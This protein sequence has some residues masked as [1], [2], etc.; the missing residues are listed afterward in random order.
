[1]QKFDPIIR[2]IP[3]MPKWLW[4]LVYVFIIGSFSEFMPDG[5]LFL[6][7]VGL[8][9]AFKGVS[10]RQKQ[11]Q[12]QDMAKRIQHLKDTV[13]L[14]DRQE[15]ELKSYILNNDSTN[16]KATATHLLEK[17]QNI[18]AES[19]ELKGHLPNEVFRR[20]NSRA[21]E[22]KVDTMMQL[23]HLQIESHL[24]RHAEYDSQIE[25][26]A[27]ELKEYYQNVQTDH[28]RILK[29]LEEADN[30]EELTA[31]H[32][33][34]MQQFYDILSGYLQIKESPKDYYN[35]EARLEQA[36][37]AIKKF[38]LDL[39]EN[40]RQLNESALKDFEVSL[41]MMQDPKKESKY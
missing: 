33:S 34:S 29:K 38:D 5:I 16:F 20:I 31:I 9:A 3:R 15:R 6:S 11:L 2:F 19:Y 4:L 21:D 30:T 28:K 26:F 27:P 24:D 17:I 12:G 22:I 8:G 35:A 18:K 10:K 40:L 7:M 37:E 1:M 23:E 13:H 25:K 14:A 36:L 41:R 39:D 32:D